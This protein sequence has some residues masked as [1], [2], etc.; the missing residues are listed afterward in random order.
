M[1]YS[2]ACKKA[3]ETNPMTPYLIIYATSII[4]AFFAQAKIPKLIRKVLVALLTLTLSYLL[5]T[6][7]SLIGTDTENY[8]RIF[9]FLDRTSINS[10]YS[11]SALG[12]EPGFL[13]TSY[14]FNLFFESYYSV[15]FCFG[16]II[17]N[18]YVRAAVN[19]NLNLVIFIAALFSYT[20]LYFMSFNILRQCVA[21]SIVFFSVRY[22]TLGLNRKFI[23]TC[24]VATAFHY[25][26]IISL[27]FLVIYKYRSILYRF[28]YLVV[29]AVSTLSTSLLF[30]FSSLSERYSSYTT[31]D[32]V[33]SLPSLTVFIFY[34]IIFIFSVLGIKLIDKEQ[35][36]AFKFY[37]V[38]YAI[39]ISLN[40]FFYISGLSN[41]GL[42]RVAFYFAWPS[43]F[44]ID[45]GLKG[46]KNKNFRYLVNTLVF[47]F[48]SF[49]FIY[50]LVHKGV[51]LVPFQKN[52]EINFLG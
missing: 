11:L 23:L 36:Q 26:A 1:I 15:F 2:C 6:R 49:F 18:F 28:W 29:F 12:L 43:I 39:F 50:T 14:I 19:S 8:I 38:I 24:L 46:L 7:N 10:V 35:R 45:L 51:E 13:L 30:F 17:Y 20:G 3:N 21:L 25:S 16:L 40:L 37:S 34:L 31:A 5:L 32:D 47:A 4:L 44:I 41:Q 33:T 9:E 52:N 48:L 22:L 42:V 27:L